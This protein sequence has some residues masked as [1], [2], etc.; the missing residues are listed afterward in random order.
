MFTASM[1]ASD[2]NIPVITAAPR[3]RRQKS[4]SPSP[5]IIAPLVR[6]FKENAQFKMNVTSRL[7]YATSA[8]MTAQP[9]VEYRLNLRKNSSLR[10]RRKRALAKS[11][12]DTDASADNA[13][14]T[15]D[16]AAARMATIMNPRT[17]GGMADRMKIGNT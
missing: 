12:V 13:A 7:A 15:D 4:A 16:I 14:A 9:T 8:S 11:M 3:P 1:A 5:P 2:T 17:T 10:C 6:P